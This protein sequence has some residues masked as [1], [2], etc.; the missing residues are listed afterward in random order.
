MAQ[1]S[2]VD[3]LNRRISA[4]STEIGTQRNEVRKLATDVS[5][6]EN[7]R[8]TISG[9]QDRVKRSIDDAR[10]KVGRAKANRRRID[11]HLSKLQSSI[12]EQAQLI[13]QYREATDNETAIRIARRLFLAVNGRNT[14]PPR[15]LNTLDDFVLQHRLK[16]RGHAAALVGNALGTL[17]KLVVDSFSQLKDLPRNAK[18]LADEV[19]GIVEKPLEALKGKVADEVKG[20]ISDK[21]TAKFEESSETF[22]KMQDLLKDPA[23][24]DEAIQQIREDSRKQLNE[25]LF[26][27]KDGREAAIAETRKALAASENQLAAAELALQAAQTPMPAIIEALAEFDD[28]LEQPRKDLTQAQ[29]ALRELEEQREQLIVDASRGRVK[30]SDSRQLV[31]E[32]ATSVGLSSAGRRSYDLAA[33]GVTEALLGLPQRGS[34]TAAAS[35]S[36]E[37]RGECEVCKRT[38]DG[39][40]R[41]TTHQRS[42]VVQEPRINIV[43]KLTL[44]GNAATLSGSRVSGREAG[45]ATLS[46]RATP[47]LRQVS[48]SAHPQCGG[49]NQ[50]IVEGPGPAT[51]VQINVSKVTEFETSLREP[52]EL[53]LF[54]DSETATAGNSSFFL[55]R[56]RVSLLARIELPDGKI[57]EMRNFPPG[58]VRS[59]LATGASAFTLSGS[60]GVALVRPQKAGRTQVE[61]LVNDARGKVA[62]RIRSADIRVGEISAERKLPSGSR[63]VDL[64]SGSTARF[65]IS[66]DGPL[67]T[68]NWT[69]DWAVNGVPLSAVGP[70]KSIDFKKST[71]FLGR[72]AVNSLTPT[73]VTSLGRELTVS[74]RIMDGTNSI[75]SFNFA[76][77]RPLLRVQ[78][79]R[80]TFKDTNIGVEA[81]D[82]FTPAPTTQLA[83]IVLQFRTSQRRE[84]DVP[85]SFSR[86]QVIGLPALTVKDG[87]E[88]GF[89]SLSGRGIVGSKQT[90]RG[91]VVAKFDDIDARNRGIIFQGNSTVA[92]VA[93]TLNR[94]TFRRSGAGGDERYVL[95]VLGPADMSRYKARFLL[96]SRTVESGFR[97]EGV[98]SVASVPVSA[99]VLDAVEVVN[100][101]GRTLGRLEVGLDGTPLPDL[102]MSLRVPP[103]AAPGQPVVVALNISNL[104]FEEAFDFRCK[105]QLDPAFGTLDHAENNVSPLSGNR[106]ICVNTLRLN[107]DD[108]LVGRELPLSVD[109]VRQVGT[110][111]PDA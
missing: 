91:V 8:G 46:A 30:F 34:V 31:K 90:G 51:S 36:L 61:F 107:D 105:W 95:D 66:V 108:R 47:G 7:A 38:D 86:I 83:P 59:R 48:T 82:L 2:E 25:S 70:G 111:P 32:V 68:S 78:D 76:P 33:D 102:V 99:G 53:R 71:P 26:G 73:G 5:V 55:P 22:A 72:R 103:R 96:G 28:L 69:V 50:R 35:G 56:V 63:G 45:Q 23:D 29:L 21:L 9:L 79:M 104:P 89:S 49:N 19:V 24:I 4:L 39:E 18:S 98:K 87:I 3:Q 40:T 81:L 60:D 77:I 13:K 65:T 85:S 52:Q 80:F 57:S 41:C 54:K 27:N 15:R 42:S 74:A 109:V 110:R 12:F 88:V 94:L 37:Y 14:V 10:Q 16:L 84:V 106:G 44:E 58:V 67:D 17:G 75:G 43:P 64:P 6:L 11:N 62:E 1:S 92:D 20:R 93:V 101:N 97:N 100:A